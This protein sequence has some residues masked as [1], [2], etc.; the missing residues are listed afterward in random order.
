MHARWKVGAGA[1]AAAMSVAIGTATVAPSVAGAAPRLAPSAKVL[2]LRQ[3]RQIVSHLQIGSPLAGVHEVTGTVVGGVTKLTSQNW[4]GYA[5]KGAASSFTAVSGHWVQPT[6]TCSGLTESLAAF[7]VGIDGISSA[8]PTVEQDG[9]LILCFLGTPYYI[10]WWETYPGNAIQ[11]VSESVNPG[12]HITA[13]VS[14]SGSSYAMSVTDSTATSNSFSVS[15]PCGTT[16]CENLSAEWIAEAPTSAGS[17]TP[18]AQF[19]TWKVTSARTT[20]KGRSGTI[21]GVKA[22]TVYE[23]TIEDASKVVQAQPTALNST[24]SSFS[25]R[26]KSAT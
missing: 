18:L 25:V 2:A 11:V 23:I 3:V 10:D 7:W 6:G 8:D 22:P 20:Y 26:W 16:T 9:T 19:T 4:G 21:S 17:I 14:Y 12:D 13:K 5:D 15:E 24:G 1:L